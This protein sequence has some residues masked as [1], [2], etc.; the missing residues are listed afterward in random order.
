MKTN[1]IK[2]NPTKTNPTKSNDMKIYT[3]TRSFLQGILAAAVLLL[4]A[5]PAN[6][7]ASELTGV[8]RQV[9]HELVMLPYYGVFDKLLTFRQ[10]C[11]S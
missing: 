1:T 3:T 11:R 10:K 8:A 2:T 6:L 5:L 9:R 4:A 7:A